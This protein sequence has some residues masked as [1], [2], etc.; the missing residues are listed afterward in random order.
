MTDKHIKIIAWITTDND[1]PEKFY[2][3]H[4]CFL[5]GNT[6]KNL[7]GSKKRR[8]IVILILVYKIN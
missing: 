1:N 4:F 2:M 3:N 7:L 6:I 8:K 5:Q